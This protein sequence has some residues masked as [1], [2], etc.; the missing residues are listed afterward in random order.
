MQDDQAGGVRTRRIHRLASPNSPQMRLRTVTTKSAPEPL[1]LADNWQRD[2]FAVTGAAKLPH[3]MSLCS[4]DVVC[5]PQKEGGPQFLHAVPD[6]RL[7]SAEGNS[8]G[9][10]DLPGRHAVNPGHRQRSRLRDGEP[11]EGPP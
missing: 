4:P 2:L 11:G 5:F 3:V 9:V 10:G 1:V 8:L 6:P 7:S